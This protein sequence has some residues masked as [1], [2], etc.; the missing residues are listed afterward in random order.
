MKKREFQMPKSNGTFTWTK[1]YLYGSLDALNTFKMNT[2]YGNEFIFAYLR[3]SRQVLLGLKC[4]NKICFVVF[5]VKKALTLLLRHAAFEIDQSSITVYH[6]EEDR[7]CL[8]KVYI[9]S[10]QILLLLLYSKVLIRPACIARA[11]SWLAFAVPIFM[12]HENMKMAQN[13]T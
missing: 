12:G 5:T 1:T 8:Q 2:V 7:L 13:G 9:T 6:R 3:T 10:I 4:C 11:I